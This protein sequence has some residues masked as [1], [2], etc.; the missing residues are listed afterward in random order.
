MLNDKFIPKSKK[1]LVMG[2]RLSSVAA[3]RD[4]LRGASISGDINN[5]IKSTE[6]LSK[7]VAKVCTVAYLSLIYFIFG[8]MKWHRQFNIS[9]SQIVYPKI[10]PLSK[11]HC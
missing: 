5:R 11:I 7:P 2:A 1:F 9:M 8:E 4:C 6:Y 10:I 3:Q